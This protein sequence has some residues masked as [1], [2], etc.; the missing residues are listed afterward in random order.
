MYDSKILHIPKSILSLKDF[1]RHENAIVQKANLLKIKT[2]TTQ[3]AVHPN[4]IKNNERGG[5]LVFFNCESK[6]ILLWGNFLKN[7]YLKY[8]KNKNFYYS[9]NLF[10]PKIKKIS[11]RKKGIL[12]CLGGKR[13]IFENLQML[14]LIT[15]DKEYFKKNFKIFIKMHPSMKISDFNKHFSQLLRG[16]DFKIFVSKKNSNQFIV[17]K[18]LFAITG[19]SGSYYDCLYLGLKT[20]FFDYGYKISNLLPR[21]FN[22]LN[23]KSN[24]KM[25]LLKI[26]KIPT[27]V[28]IDRSSLILKKVWGISK[29]N[30]NFVNLTDQISKNI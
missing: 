24:L 14:N 29:E 3:H 19:L 1:Q 26:E 30:K 22:N 5:N 28:W 9:R 21:S 18:N 25:E 2:F 17:N 16:V 27:S 4:F 7:I 13:H 20:L 11:L 6:N 8:N 15:K 23:S 10:M 12:F